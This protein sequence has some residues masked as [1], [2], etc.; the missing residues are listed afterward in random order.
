[1]PSFIKRTI[2]F[3][4][5]FGALACAEQIEVTEPI[6]MDTDFYPLVFGSYRDYTVTERIYFTRTDIETRVYQIR[7]EIGQEFQNLQG[8]KS[9][10]LKRY[11]RTG[12]NEEWK[13]DSL[14]ISRIDTSPTFRCVQIEN[15]VPFIKLVFP[16]ALGKS[17]D[18]NALNSHL[19]E[20]Y[21]ITEIVDNYSLPQGSLS[22]PNCVVVLQQEDDDKITI[23]DIR[24][25]VYSANIGMVHRYN[26]TL[27]YCSR[28]ECLGQ[29]IVE[30]GRFIEMSLIEYGQL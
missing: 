30:S 17:W 10:E 16:V 26:E 24:Y 7:E 6:N 28:P 29:E 8:G 3:G 20:S 4:L 14:W 22:L 21:K 9:Y 13:L 23:R 11:S 2:F 27:K 1:M 15:N 18:G 25:E 12:A 19:A 5:M